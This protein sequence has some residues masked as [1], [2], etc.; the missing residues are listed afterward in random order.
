[1]ISQELHPL[2]RGLVEELPPPDSHWP[3]QMRRRW[4]DAARSILGLLYD[5]EP[6]T[7]GSPEQEERAAE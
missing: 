5:D 7:T 3:E 2:I 6:V 4:L 1:M